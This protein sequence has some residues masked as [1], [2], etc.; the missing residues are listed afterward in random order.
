MD[1]YVKDEKDVALKLNYRIKEDDFSNAGAASS[2]IKNKLRQLGIDAKI[3]RRIAVA[4]YEGE[5]NLAI[6]SKGGTIE[7]Y[8]KPY[9]VEIY[10]EDIGPGIE[11]VELAMTKGYSTATSKIREMGFGAGMGLPNMQKVSDTFIIQSTLGVGTQIKMI[12]NT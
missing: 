10:I 4:S 7:I 12:I 11:D 9:C 2:Q 3:L 5:I 1:Q 6:H 8:I